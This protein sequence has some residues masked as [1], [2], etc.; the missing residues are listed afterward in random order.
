[1]LSD[2]LVLGPEHSN[3]FLQ[4]IPVFQSLFQLAA[5][6]CALFFLPSQLLS[7]LLQSLLLLVVDDDLLHSLQAALHVGV[8]LDLRVQVLFVPLALLYVLDV[9]QLLQLQG[10]LGQLAL[11]H[12]LPL[13]QKLLSLPPLQ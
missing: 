6:G 7:Q 12:Q 1:M 11:S 2:L 10:S 3:L 4:L 9:R 5:S 13:S 8:G